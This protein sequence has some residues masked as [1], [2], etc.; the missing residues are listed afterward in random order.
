M[1]TKAFSVACT[2]LVASA[3]FAAEPMTPSDIR[4]TFFN[5]KPFIASTPGGT[6]FHM[7]FTPDGKMT[8]E[9]LAQAGYKDSGTWKLSA[10]GFCTTWQHAKPNCFTVVPDGENKWS[11][12]KGGTTIATTIAVWSK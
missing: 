3:A 1:S 11:V 4:A 8:R 7:T 9:P 6:Q 12:L 5:G 10:K 2:L